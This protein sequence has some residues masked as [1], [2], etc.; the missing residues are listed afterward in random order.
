MC[1]PEDYRAHLTHEGESARAARLADV[2]QHLWI[3]D[4]ARDRGDHHRTTD[5]GGTS[6]SHRVGFVGAALAF[7]T[8]VVTLSFLLT[9]PEAWVQALGDAHHG[10]Y[11]SGA[12]RS[13]EATPFSSLEPG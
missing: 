4:G 2:Q 5:P 9:T 12:G 13:V 6:F 8:P 7:A 3:L 11:L 10:F 1:I